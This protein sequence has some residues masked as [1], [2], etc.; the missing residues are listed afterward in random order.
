M[1]EIRKK[2]WKICWPFPVHESDK[3]PSF[4][5]LD[6]PKYSCRCC[7]NSALEIAAKDTHKEDQKTD[8]DCC[9]TE[10]RSG[11]NCNNEAL[12]SGIQQDPM[13]DAV[14]RR[15]IDLNTALNCCINDYL[16]NSNEKG[17]KAGVVPSRIIGNLNISSIYLLY[18]FSVCHLIFCVPQT[19]TVA[20]RIISTT[21]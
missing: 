8:L 16:P 21:K 14:E 20:W 17:K 15:E 19:L 6:A 13:L 3:Q 9:S 2:D 1:S 11:S 10:C 7:Q 12:K 4:L 5:P 18:H